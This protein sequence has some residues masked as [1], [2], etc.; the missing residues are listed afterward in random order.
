MI[1][2]DQLLTVSPL[3]L[4]IF[5][6]SPKP[7]FSVALILLVTLLFVSK[8]SLDRATGHLVSDPAT[9]HFMHVLL[10]KRA[11]FDLDHLVEENMLADVPWR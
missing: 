5:F 2:D 4:S 7:R 8:H 11:T 3:P 1:R 9:T 10:H 6:Y